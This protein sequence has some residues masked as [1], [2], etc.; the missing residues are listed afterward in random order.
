M[1][2]FS[3]HIDAFLFVSE[4]NNLDLIK[5][6]LKNNEDRIFEVDEFNRDLLSVILHLKNEEFLKLILP[7]YNVETINQKNSHMYP[8]LSATDI[9]YLPNIQL[10]LDFG[11]DIHTIQPEIKECTVLNI[12]FKRTEPELIHFLLKN[13]LD[14]NTKINKKIDFLTS[15]FQA[16]NF[17]SSE[18]ILEFLEQNIEIFE[19]YNLKKNK[20]HFFK[21]YI[22]FMLARSSDSYTMEMHEKFMEKFITLTKKLELEESFPKNNTNIKI[23]I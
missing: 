9:G 13:N 15:L 12:A 10:L 8:I 21:H 3:N 14:L 23:K 7:Y 5:E 22:P 19:K 11:A 1:Q 20:D 4:K 18:F 17:L 6:F 16:N 2:N